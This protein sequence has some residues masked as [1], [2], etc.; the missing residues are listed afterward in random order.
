MVHS[1]TIG[2]RAPYHKRYADMHIEKVSYSEGGTKGRQGLLSHSLRVTN[3][4]YPPPK[5]QTS[6]RHANTVASLG[7]HHGHESRYSRCPFSSVRHWT[8]RITA[9]SLGCPP[10]QV[11]VRP[12]FNMQPL[13]KGVAELDNTVQRSFCP[14]RTKG[15][16]A[17]YAGG[18]QELG[19][20]ITHSAPSAGQNRTNTHVACA[21]AVTSVTGGHAQTTSNAQPNTLLLL[22][23]DELDLNNRFSL[24]CLP[25]RYAVLSRRT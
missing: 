16:N 12:Y 14:S 15:R 24:M 9:K 21:P 7:V 17:P 6:S 18:V 8:V 19:R 10:A 5:Q 25:K 13:V 3:E 4:P 22:K 11:H 20:R 1:H 2:P 23:P